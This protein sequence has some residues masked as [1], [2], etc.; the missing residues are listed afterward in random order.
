[1]II[2][3]LVGHLSSTDGH[4]NQKVYQRQKF[5]PQQVLFNSNS[6]HNLFLV[7]NSIT[8]PRLPCFIAILSRVAKHCTIALRTEAL[9]SKTIKAWRHLFNN[10]SITQM[11][12]LS[13]LHHPI[14]EWRANSKSM[15][16]LIRS[17]TFIIRLQAG[18]ILSLKD[19]QAGISEEWN[20]LISLS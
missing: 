4:L 2:V 11:Y 18:S 5:Y 8:T 9:Y 12:K 13:C 6:R 10:N 1:M 14:K 19:Q 15:T 7:D 3:T 16:S 17:R 20:L